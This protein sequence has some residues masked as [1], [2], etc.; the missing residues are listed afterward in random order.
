[1]TTVDAQARCAACA[2][3]RNDPAFLEAALAGLASLSSGHGSVRSDDGICLRH[4]RYL[5]AT[6]WCSDFTQAELGGV[7]S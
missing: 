6:S 3:F 4:E 7:R 2:H 5:A 1:M